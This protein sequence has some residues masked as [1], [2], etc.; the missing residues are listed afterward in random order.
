MLYFFEVLGLSVPG[1]SSEVLR[2]RESCEIELSIFGSS[3]VSKF[4]LS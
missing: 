1:V 4:E 2:M 3:Q